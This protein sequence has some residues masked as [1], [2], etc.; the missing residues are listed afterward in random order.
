MRSSRAVA[1]A[2]IAATV[3]PLCAMVGLQGAKA[4]GRQ[5]STTPNAAAAEVMRVYQGVSDRGSIQEALDNAV[6]SA[7]N[8]LPGADR[9]V[10]YR[11]RE[12]TGEQGGIAGI[13]R[14]RV[15]IE[16]LD[17]EPIRS[18]RNSGQAPVENLPG[19]LT[20]ELTLRPN[21]VRQ[22]QTATFELTVRNRSDQPARITF[23]TGQQFDFEV[24]RDNRRVWRW[25]QDQAFTQATSALALRPGQA[26]TFT[27]RWN[28]R[29]DLGERVIPGRYE[30]RGFLASGTD[31]RNIGKLVGDTEPLTVTQR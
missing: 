2:A 23:P 9:M 12:I 1:T 4:Q 7:L 8:S 27:G 24:W 19:A 26:I 28:L 15:S 22:G 16:T 3:L 11:V 20:S 13:N 25:S 6:G 17:A 10:R 29:N 30:V 14:V 18:P 5:G 31:G 21:R